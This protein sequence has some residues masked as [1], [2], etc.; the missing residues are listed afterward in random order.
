S[1]LHARHADVPPKI[2]GVLDDEAWSGAPL[3][4]EAWVSYNPMRGERASEQTR[5]WVAYDNHALYF[6]FKCFDTEPEKIRT[7]ISR[8]DDAFKDDWVGLSL[9][10]SRAGQM[11]YHMFVNPSG[12]QMDGINSGSNGEDFAPDWVWQSAGRVD[13]DGYTVEIRLPLQAIRFRSGANV[14]MGVLFWRRLSRTG[15]SWAWPEVLP[16]K[17]VLDTHV[18]VILD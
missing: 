5:V 7:N 16:G 14:R 17:W 13:A 8:R 12:I 11:A 3:P 9:D 18:A 6:A 4:L 10:S 15:V 2:D 1:E